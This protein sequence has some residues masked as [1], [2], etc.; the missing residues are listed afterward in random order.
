MHLKKALI[1]VQINS[2]ICSSTYQQTL[3]LGRIA[4]LTT[5]LLPKPSFIADWKRRE[6]KH[7]TEKRVKAR[8]WK[9]QMLPSLESRIVFFFF[10]FLSSFFF[11][12]ENFFLFST[13]FWSDFFSREKKGLCFV[14]VKWMDVAL[15]IFCSFS[16]LK[17]LFESR[18]LKA[19]Y[20]PLLNL[21]KR[22]F[23]FCKLK[24]RSFFK[25]EGLKINFYLKFIN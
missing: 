11:E 14:D 22:P 5:F 2:P 1:L 17:S 24:I 20:R 18:T 10:F 23:Y 12:V 9:K 16:L 4:T 6:N 19:N 8:V 7:R 3:L 21:Q 25:G 13:F 15:V